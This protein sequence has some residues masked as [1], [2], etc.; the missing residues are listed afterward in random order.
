ML[1]SLFLLLKWFHLFRQWRLAEKAKSRLS[2]RW[3]L[4]GRKY[5]DHGRSHRKI[6]TQNSRHRQA[7]SGGIQCLIHRTDDAAS[8]FFI[9]YFLKYSYYIIN[10]FR[11]YRF[12]MG[13][14][15]ILNWY[16][17]DTLYSLKKFYNKQFVGYFFGKQNKDFLI[18]LFFLFPCVPNFS[19][20]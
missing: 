14:G 5:L 20:Q 17:L 19:I 15:E 18:H 2:L 12:F 6:Y 13:G 11:N 3:S 9:Y 1:Y 8:V 7:V 16:F 10:I 4:S